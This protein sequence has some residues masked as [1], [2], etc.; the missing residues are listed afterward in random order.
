MQ[1]VL[2]DMSSATIA[3]ATANLAAFTAFKAT[4]RGQ[5]LEEEE[6]K[7]EKLNE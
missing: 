4:N 5:L 7:S 3:H 2:G 1:E 6:K